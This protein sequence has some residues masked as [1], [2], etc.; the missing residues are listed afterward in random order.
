MKTFFRIIIRQAL[1]AA[2]VAGAAACTQVKSPS[3]NAQMTDYAYIPQQSAH[4]TIYVE[5]QGLDD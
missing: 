1:L 2:L 3:S 5:P 4:A